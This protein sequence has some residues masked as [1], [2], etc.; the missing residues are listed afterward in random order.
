V[1]AD[2]NRLE[3]I[4][5]KFAAL[6]YNRFL[7]H[8]HHSYANALEYL[9]LHNLRKRRYHLDALVLNQV[10]RGFKYCS[11]LLE[12]VDLRISTSLCS[13]LDF[14]VKICLLLDA[15]Q[16]LMSAGTL[17]YSKQEMFLS[18]SYKNHGTFQFIRYE[19]FSV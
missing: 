14:L 11:S 12:A 9:K 13:V 5:Q 2:A 8:D 19:F 4:Q 10:Y 7:P 17:I 15:H 18:V 6:C 16:L 1:S 3:R